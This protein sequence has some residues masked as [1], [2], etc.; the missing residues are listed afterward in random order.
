M[1][2]EMNILLEKLQEAIDDAIAESSRIDAI[3]AEMKR[4]GYD[5]CLI[6]ESSVAISPI[7]ET[8][9]ADAVPEPRLALSGDIE[10]TADDLEFL[11]ELNISADAA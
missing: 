10:L 8:Q 4:S 5:L 6:L 11:Q 7:E 1:T 3:V 2:S 9:P